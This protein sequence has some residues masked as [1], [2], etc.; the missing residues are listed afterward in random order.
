M[1][2]KTTDGARLKRL[3]K[4]YADEWANLSWISS[5]HPDDHAGIRARYKRARQ[6]LHRAIDELTSINLAPRSV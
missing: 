1:K 6:R 2:A 4:A 3:A 5:C